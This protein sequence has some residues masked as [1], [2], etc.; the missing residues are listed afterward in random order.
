MQPNQFLLLKIYHKLQKKKIECH[1]QVWGKFIGSQRVKYSTVYSRYS[2]S[3]SSFLGFW[4]S[5]LVTFKPDSTQDNKTKKCPV[6]NQSHTKS[7]GTL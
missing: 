1:E 7:T 2:G 4:F 5:A 6:V 3:G